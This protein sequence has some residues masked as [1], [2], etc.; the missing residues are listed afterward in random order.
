M[1]FYRRIP[2]VFE[3]I[4]ILLKKY[5]NMLDNGEGILYYASSTTIQ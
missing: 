4:K 3:N 1:G 5:K 2:G